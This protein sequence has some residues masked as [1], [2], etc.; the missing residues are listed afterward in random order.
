MQAAQATEGI[1]GPEEMPLN[2]TDK[3]WIHQEIRYARSVWDKIRGWSPLG[4]AVAILIFGLTQWS[5]YIE[6][7]TTTGDRLKAIES[8]LEIV[9]LGQLS[10]NPTDPKNAAD[11]ETLL[12]N[13]KSKKIPLDATA[14]KDFGNIFLKAAQTTPAAWDASLSFLDYRSFLN[15]GS[16]PV[17]RKS[18]SPIPEGQ[19]ASYMAFHGTGQLTFE[20]DYSNQ[21]VP[22]SQAFIYQRVDL[23]VTRNV[24]HPYL[25]IHNAQGSGELDLDDFWLR[26]VIFEGVRI[27]YTGGPLILENVYFVNCTFDVTNNSVGQNFVAAALS[28][29]TGITF[30]PS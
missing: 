11:A 26:N 8:S 7:R 15:Q 5:G 18:F 29:S 27:H 2:E 20:A 13:A 22:I 4:A 21:L 23:P 24:G 6:F 10:R 12:T 25:L 28:S 30:R 9:R 17:A 3:A 16:F 1:V 19:L 14:I